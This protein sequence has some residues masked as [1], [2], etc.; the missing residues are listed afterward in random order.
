MDEVET[1]FNKTDEDD[2]NELYDENNYEFEMEDLEI[3]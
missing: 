1:G 3:L 2:N